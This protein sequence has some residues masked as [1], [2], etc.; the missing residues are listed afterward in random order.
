LDLLVSQL[1]AEPIYMDARIDTQLEPLTLSLQPKSMQR[2]IGNLMDNGLLYGQRLSVHLRSE[3]KVALL[4]IRDY[5]PG[6]AAADMAKV[7]LQNVRLDYAEH[8]N[9][10]G[11]GLGLSISRN[12]VRAHGGDI[13]L[14]NHPKADWWCGFNCRGELPCS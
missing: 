8:V 5:G 9:T 1:A 10:K 4:T 7:F 11:T 12:V 3:N 6:I 14:R 2:A 13:R